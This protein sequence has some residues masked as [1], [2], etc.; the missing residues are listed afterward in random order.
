MF[1]RHLQYVLNSTEKLKKSPGIR[2]L[3]ENT[4]LAVYLI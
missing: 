1:I 3:A 4:E 2:V